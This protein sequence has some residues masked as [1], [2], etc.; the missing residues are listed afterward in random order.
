MI[1]YTRE[2]TCRLGR[3]GM[4][5]PGNRDKTPTDGRIM[6]AHLTYLELQDLLADP[7]EDNRAYLAT[8]V[9][10]QI[11]DIDLSDNERQIAN[12]IL[13][14]LAKDAAVLVRKALA[15]SMKFSPDLP[16][17]IAFELAKDVEDIALPLLES[18]SV[19]SD[20]DLIA[21]VRGGST[22]KQIAIAGRENVG[23]LVSEALV[24]TG[25][26]VVVAELVRNQSA[27]IP[28][29][30]M[31]RVVD[32]FGDDESING[33]LA[34][35][36]DVSAAIC[37]RLVVLVSDEMCK[38]LIE[39]GKVDQAK[40]KELLKESRERA[41]VDL[42]RNL[43]QGREIR[44]L[45]HQLKINDRLTPSVIVR[46]ACTGEMRFFEEALAALT[47]VEYEKAWVLIH[48]KGTLGFKALF[49]RSGLP[50]TL[51]LPCRIAVNVFNE[52]EPEMEFDGDEEF[53]RKMLQMV[54]TQYEDL[55]GED[56]EFLM[57]RL[58]SESL[59]EGSAAPRLRAAVELSAAS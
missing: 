50:Q 27:N 17:D 1:R 49:E 30:L 46:A 28:E 42:A 23:E 10:G 6:R 15:E 8:Q 7:G 29:L 3:Y 48:D 5:A 47:G 33:P 59:A 13:R 52:L 40:A 55:E 39:T 31:Q 56:L 4:V 21:L 35:R 57:T 20:G 44:K 38:R 25:K 53:G 24:D 36:S 51:Y 9:A 2:H 22:E 16:G 37:E 11:Q 12:E 32:E 18:S 45:V 14:T 34:M 58:A 19:F 54:L 26:N 43:G 41:T